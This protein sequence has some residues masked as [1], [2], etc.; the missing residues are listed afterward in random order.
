MKINRI[1]LLS[2]WS[3]ILTFG[4]NAQTSVIDFSSSLHE[5][6]DFGGC[7][8][9]IQP[10]PMNASNPTGRIVN[11][12]SQWE[13]I[14]LDSPDEVVLSATNTITIDFYSSVADSAL[15][16]LKLEDGTDV[17]VDCYV[18]V[19]GTGW[20]TVT[21]DFSNALVSGGGV[22][23]NATGRYDRMVFF[24]NGPT[25]VAG[26]YHIDNI[27]YPNYESANTIDVVY[28]DLAWADEFAY[29]GPVDTSV[30]FPETV[31][32][33]A[34]GWFNGE[35]QHYTD[36]T[37]NS[38]VSNG[39]LKIVAKAESYTFQGLTLD[40]TSARLTSKYDFTYGRVEIR[41]K[42][43]FGDGTWPALWM[44]GTSIG[45][46]VH[47]PTLGWP[48][49]GEIDIMEH[50]GNDQNVIHGSIHNR[51]SHG[52]TVNTNKLIRDSVSD[53]FHVYSMNW[54]PDQ[55]SFLMD[56]QLY[57]TYHPDPKDM[58]NWPFDLPHFFILNVAM[59]S[60]WYDID[61]NFVESEM[62]VDYV[63]VYQNNVSLDESSKLQNPSMVY[64]N[65]SK[66]NFTVQGLTQSNSGYV[67][68]DLSGR[69]VA[70]GVLKSDSYGEASLSL[71]LPSGQYVLRVQSESGP[72]VEWISIQ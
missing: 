12:A 20:Q 66:G 44:L 65:P 8:F 37:D 68:F 29:F 28:T 41:A 42:L 63:R 53:D 19:G 31:P 11:S 2:A 49:C 9:S 35:K 10:D 46:S 43:P 7:N 16:L 14:F 25:Y 18:T 26:T 23:I 56:G 69:E 45:N 67:I 72:L 1:L 50:W 22:P 48:D 52:A 32:P 36:R 40:Y 21:F 71:N 64:P 60:G 17:D 3:V 33:N 30:W 47:P 51:S 55:I 39:T 59:G 13:G 24:V 58:D 34:W 5:F 6:G 54:S 4:L 27:T 38:Y 61:P 70:N 57:Y 62:E 15:L